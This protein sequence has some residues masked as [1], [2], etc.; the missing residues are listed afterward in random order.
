MA[1]EVRHAL[2]KV[3]RTER[4]EI[5]R[6]IKLTGNYWNILFRFRAHLR[7]LGRG[8]RFTFFRASLKY[9]KL[10]FDRENYEPRRETRFRR[11]ERREFRK[12]F[13]FGAATKSN[14]VSSDTN[15]NVLRSVVSPRN[16]SVK[17]RSNDSRVTAS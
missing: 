7:V 17:F 1:V 15:S 4:M 3:A 5:T 13:I 11:K 2:G 8:F 10:H 14:Y 16:N 6:L 9:S 12:N